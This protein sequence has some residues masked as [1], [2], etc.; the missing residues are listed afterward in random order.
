MMPTLPMVLDDVRT[1]CLPGREAAVV[2][3]AWWALWQGLNVNDRRPVM[4][5]P[6]RRD[7]HQRQPQGR[8]RPGWASK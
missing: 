6:R 5:R 1:A 7:H 3:E 4:F 8:Y 2:S